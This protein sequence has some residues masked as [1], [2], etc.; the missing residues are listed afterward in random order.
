MKNKFKFLKTGYFCYPLKDKGKK[1]KVLDS[2]SLYYKDKRTTELL[3][4]TAKN[5]CSYYLTIA[6]D[7]IWNAIKKEKL[8]KK[9][10]N[11]WIVP[12][13]LGVLNKNTIMID[14]DILKPV[15]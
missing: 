13:R 14:I 7:I 12:I 5:P 10:K 9:Y 8:D 11:C 3:K 1:F 6:G 4:I 2:T 15:K